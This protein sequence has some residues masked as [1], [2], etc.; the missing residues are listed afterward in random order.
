MEGLEERRLLT[1]VATFVQATGALTVQAVGLSGDTGVLKVD[2]NS[3]EILLDGNDSGNFVDTGAN[4]ATI[5]VPIQ[6]EANT[7]IDSNFIID[8]N[9]GSFFEAPAGYAAP[10]AYPAGTLFNFTGSTAFEPGSSLTIRGRAGVADTFTVA[11]DKT[12]QDTGV[13][14]LTEPPNQLN[15][16]NSLTVAYGYPPAAEAGAAANVNATPGISGHLTLD[17]LDGTGGNDKLIINDPTGVA[18]DWTLNGSEIAGPAFPAAPTVP[19]TPAPLPGTI[20]DITY[21]NIANLQFNDTQ[22][23]DLLTINSTAANTTATT[24]GTTVVD[25]N[26]PL[27]FPVNL[28][29]AP[30]TT[31]NGGSGTTASS[32]LDI[33]GAPGGNNDFYVDGGSVSLAAAGTHPQYNTPFTHLGAT[34]T[35][36][37]GALKELQVAGNGGNNTVTVQVPPTLFPGFTSETLSSTFVVYGGAVPPPAQLVAVGVQPTPVTVG[38]NLLRVLGNAPGGNTAGNDNITVSDFGGTTT[39]TGST[40]GATNIEMS[41]IAAVVIYGEGGNDTLTNA[42]TGNKAQG[43]PPVSGLLIGGSGNDTLTGGAGNDMLLGGG[44]QNT[45]I[46]NATGT[47]N[48]PTT[49]YF[50][51]HQD[52][53]GNIYDPFLTGG[54]TT[55]TITGAGAGNEL[56]V[57]GV[58]GTTG[59]TG[60]GGTGT[61]TTIGPTD[62]DM[63]TLSS[64]TVPPGFS[65]GSSQGT[66]AIDLVP[67]VP[68]NNVT[69]PL[70]E[71]TPA[72]LA[73]EQAIGE[74]SGPYQPNSAAQLEFGQ[75]LNLRGQF[76][77]YAA[78]VGRAYDDFLVDR[79]GGGTFGGANNGQTYDF[80]EGSSV[81]SNQEIQYWAS[82]GQAG[83]SVQQMQAQLLASNELRQQLPDSDQWIRFLY[84]SVLNRDPTTAE[85]TADENFLNQSDTGATRYVLALSVLMSP[86]G[87][88]AEINDI[89]YNV[90]P[91]SPSPSSTDLAAINADLAAGESLPQVAQTVSASNGNYLSYELANNVG[92]VGF[93]AGVYESVLHRA[94][95]SSDLSFWA[96]VIGS[97]V[98]EAQVGQA[99][100]SSPEARTFLIND[101]Y[102]AYLGRPAD[103]GGMS[104]WQAEFATGQLTDEEFVASLIGSPEFYARNGSTSQSFVEALYQDLLGRTAAQQDINFWVSQLAQSPRGAAQARA[105]IALEFQQSSE[106]QT[107][108]VNRWYQTYDGRAPTAS[109]LSTDVGLLQ[110]GASDEH[111]QAQILVAR[112]G[113]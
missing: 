20:G 88:T 67:T 34:L 25:Y 40:T 29:G 59:L 73:L 5:S 71:A 51:P 74:G 23:G 28:V 93:V 87:Q 110:S 48:S 80:G 50:F 44:G 38:T 14:T 57:T 103:A 19:P 94:A 70:Y 92:S 66:A 105:A 21:A 106:Y 104:Y 95:A 96:S 11:P 98:S 78:F 109:E 108:L 113:S 60:T 37:P 84:N 55:S 63:G 1:W 8:N 100:L 79:G 101:A 76:A 112:Q 18:S 9:A 97:G 39:T 107:D 15:Q 17:G 26:Q 31:T 33:V 45:L 56:V 58:I 61:G 35:Y 77:T 30:T 52:Q 22:A 2:P 36:T 86:A 54:N 91:G 64:P 83:L 72:L 81:V 47:A 41:R 42:S 69:A 49:T 7:S 75:N 12:Y 111:V 43:I 13:V 6:I 68:A 65:G 16:R 53:F 4:L 32:I 46:S 82:Q 85:L 10:A 99:I 24:L 27:A 3:G 102:E 89:Y 90:V 62:E